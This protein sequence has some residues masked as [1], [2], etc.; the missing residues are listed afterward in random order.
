MRKILETGII[1]FSVM[2]FW[3][4]IYPDLCFTKE[5]CEAVLEET[6]GDD[7]GK[8]SVMNMEEKDIFTRLCEAESGQI[9]L[10]SKFLEMLKSESEK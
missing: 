4:M 3:G 8:D 9:K 5:I 2:G 10:K 1:L 6:E 7:N